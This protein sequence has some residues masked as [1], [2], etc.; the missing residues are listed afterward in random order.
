MLACLA[1]PA[2]L[3]F[4][5]HSPSKLATMLHQWSFSMLLV[6]FLAVRLLT[7]LVCRIVKYH[8]GWIAIG[9]LP[10]E[11]Y[12]GW[13]AQKNIKPK[14]PSVLKIPGRGR[15]TTVRL[16]MKVYSCCSTGKPSSRQL[17]NIYG[18]PRAN[19]P[20]TQAAPKRCG[21]C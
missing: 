14:R 15:P 21:E 5:F 7:I 4:P 19:L 6:S 18:L 10:I 3:T 8:G 13:K 12:T 9:S 17:P 11:F 20:P 16:V 2:R 1:V